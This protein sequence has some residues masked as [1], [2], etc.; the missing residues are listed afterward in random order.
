MNTENTNEKAE[1]Q[2]TVSGSV[3]LPSDIRIGNWV[4]A[5]PYGN[6]KII[7]L[8][9]FPNGSQSAFK[10][11]E[12]YPQASAINRLNPIQ[13]SEELLLKLGAVKIDSRIYPSFNLKG[14]WIHFIN[15]LWLE[16]TTRVELKGLHHLQNIFYFKMSEELEVPDLT[17]SSLTDR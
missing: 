9:I 17:D 1:K 7:A 14:V 16:Y 11:M 12:Y 2:A 4:N 13:I 5:E 10:S 8:S 6:Y 3:I 15:G